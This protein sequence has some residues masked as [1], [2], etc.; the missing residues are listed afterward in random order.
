MNIKQGSHIFNEKEIA[1]S[2]TM[3][4]LAITFSTLMFKNVV[5]IYTTFKG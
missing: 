5:I 3:F 4:F 1:I 2:G